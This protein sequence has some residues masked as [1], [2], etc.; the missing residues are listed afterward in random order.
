MTTIVP[1]RAFVTGVGHTSRRQKSAPYLQAI[2]LAREQQF[3][4]AR[5]VFAIATAQQPDEEIAW[6]S[7]AQ[8]EKRTEAQSE[9]DSSTRRF[10]RSRAVLQKA[11]QLNPGSARICQAWGLLE[12]QA[13][14]MWAA[15]ALLER[16]FRTDARCAP[17]LRW[18]PVQAARIAVSSRRQHV[19]RR[20]L[21][22]KLSSIA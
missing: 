3:D 1:S 14:N 5:Q 12:L 16:A 13:G 21:G 20:S 15:L 9:D 11:L 8:M 6:V 22:A 7:W 4:D 17:V 18:Q 19:G 2:R 10:V